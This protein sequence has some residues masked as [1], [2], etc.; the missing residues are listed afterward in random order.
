MSILG[1]NVYVLGANM[2]ILG[3]NLY[4]LGANMFILRPNMYILGVNMYI[5]GANMYTKVPICSLWVQ[6]CT[7]LKGTAPVTA[8]VPFFLRVWELHYNASLMLGT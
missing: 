2:Y 3:A 7:F 4:I 1:P 6:K 8:F 5:L